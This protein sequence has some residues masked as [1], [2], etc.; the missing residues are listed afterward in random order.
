[1]PVLSRNT[2]RQH[3]RASSYLRAGQP[4]A[5]QN[6]LK[7]LLREQPGDTEAGLLLGEI[8]R[9]QGHLQEAT[10]QWLSLVP[11]LPDDANFIARLVP[12]LYYN[13]ESVAAKRCLDHPAVAHA[14]DP[15]TLV[16]LACAH[17]PLDEPAITL[18]LLQRA[19]AAGTDMPDVHFNH[20]QMLSFTGQIGAAESCLEAIIKRW[21]S[22]SGAF[23][24]LVRLRR[25]TESQ[26][27]ERLRHLLSQVPPGNVVHAEFQFALFKMLDDLGQHDEAWTALEAGNA[28]MRALNPYDAGEDDAFTEAIIRQ[29]RAMTNAPAAAGAD[30]GA[31]PIFIV[32]LPRSGTTLFERMLSQHPDIASAGELKDFLHQM[33]WAVDIPGSGLEGIQ[34]MIEHSDRIDFASLGHR[35][36]EQTRWRAKGRRFYIDK[37]PNNYLFVHWIHRALPQAPIL[38][39]Q[40]D[41]MD[42]CFS[43]FKAMFGNSSAWSYDMQA[44]AHHHGL[45]RRLMQHWHATLPGR[46][47][48]M[49]YAELVTDPRAAM[50]HALDHCGL[51]PDDACLQPARNTTPVSTPSSAQVREPIHTR[52]LGAWQHYATQMERLRSRLP[53]RAE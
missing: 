34:T 16:E 28:T 3:R 44:L 17:Q 15:R 25:Q 41:P 49:P 2:R 10:R 22:F 38:H 43:N 1:M 33:R 53:D 13:G 37:L 47:L 36:L 29:S 52:N 21:P 45:Y 19:I 48:D 12:H 50:Q 7:A 20:A 31:L 42:V 24:T 8:L 6:I 27:L 35:Y 23:L 39:I 14:R 18:T 5:A 26:R 40:R 30:D 9:S 4:T 32:G 51:A 11:H 46:V